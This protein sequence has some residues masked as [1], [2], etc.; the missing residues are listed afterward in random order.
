VDEAK[1]LIN[2]YFK[3]YPKVRE[4]IDGVHSFI[5]DHAMVE[6]ILGRPRRFIELPAIGA[7]LDKMPKW[8]L[9]GTAKKNLA[10]AERQSVNSI[11]Q[12]SAADVAKMAMLRCE[13]DERLKNLGV[14]MLL[15]IHDELIFEVP[16]E[17][18]DEVQPIVLEM[19]QHPFGEDLLV[20][21]DADA[22]RGYS[23]AAA[24]A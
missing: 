14:E 4:F 15:Q 20:P 6:T 11:I 17:N 1:R 13:R 2:V 3:P 5:L 23:W 7:M 8:K 18:I 12:G 21:L 24:K 9:P 22:G 10:Q 19:M 16:E